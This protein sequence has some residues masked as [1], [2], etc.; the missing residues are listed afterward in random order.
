VGAGIQGWW[1]VA[2]G[3][4]RLY[5]AARCSGCGRGGQSGAGM[6]CPRWLSDGEQGGA[7]AMKAAEE[8]KVAPQLGR[9]L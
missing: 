5:T 6:G 4:G 3:A 2:R 9:P 7:R 1:S 8:E